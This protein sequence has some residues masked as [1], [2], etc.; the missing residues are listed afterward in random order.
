MGTLA[1]G[2]A[3]DFNNIL[4]HN[5]RILGDGDFR[6]AEFKYA[7]RDDIEQVMKGALRAKKELV[8]QILMF[9]R[10][11]DYKRD[12]LKIHLI[13]KESLALL[14]ASMPASI[15]INRSIDTKTGT[16]AG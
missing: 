10:Q 4:T 14:R 2:I 8:Q 11:T 13:V 16:G 12:A 7:A 5:H 1:G 6:S 9:G 15:E 3:H